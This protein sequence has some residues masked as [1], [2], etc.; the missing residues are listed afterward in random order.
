MI[1]INS[2]IDVLFWVIHPNKSYPEKNHTF[3]CKKQICPI[4][5]DTVMIGD[6]NK[7]SLLGFKFQ[8]NNLVCPDIRHSCTV[9]DNFGFTEYLIFLSYCTII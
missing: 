1:C 5:K 2:T 6:I 3:R 9:N 7:M 8:C 4:T